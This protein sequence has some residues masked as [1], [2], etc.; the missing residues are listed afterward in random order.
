MKTHYPANKDLWV[1]T[2]ITAADGRTF[3][4]IGWRGQ[5]DWI[6]ETGKQYQHLPEMNHTIDFRPKWHDFEAAFRV[7]PAFT[8]D[9]GIGFGIVSHANLQL[10]DVVLADGF[11]NAFDKPVI[12]L[13]WG[14]TG[15]GRHKE[16]RM[17]YRTTPYG[18]ATA[19]RVLYVARNCG[20]NINDYVSGF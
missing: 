1:G 6:D 13:Q 7:T 3:T 16:D 20:D 11:M 5:A 2:R 15:H 17:T 14:T 9:G 4:R 12:E 8:G 19:K 10:G 18:F